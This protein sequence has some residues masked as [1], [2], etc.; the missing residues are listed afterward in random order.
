ME[1]DDSVNLKVHPDDEMMNYI[2]DIGFDTDDYFNSGKK[3]AL[4]FKDGIS[5]HKPS[6]LSGKKILDYGCGHGR[7]C[8]YIPK[9]FSPSKFVVADVWDGAVNFCAEEFKA[10]P[11]LITDEKSLST[12]NEKFDV[13]FAYSVFT[14]LPPSSFNFYISDIS[15]C[16]EDDGIILFTTKGEYDAKTRGISLTDSYNYSVNV[17]PN[18]TKGRLPGSKYA[19]MIVTRQFVE[20]AL[21]SVGLK[22]LE[23]LPDSMTHQDLYIAGPQ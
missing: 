19:V 2:I 21:N 4:T 7:I 6:L 9:L 3:N 18:E 1:I 10:T 14:H 8:R 20:N 17:I 11:F 23:H 5:R 16:L 12:Y 13:I 22:L 15:K